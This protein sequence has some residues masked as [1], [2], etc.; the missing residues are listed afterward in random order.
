MVLLVVTVL[1]HGISSGITRINAVQLHG[2]SSGITRSNGVIIWHF[3]W[4]YS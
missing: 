3:Q 2:I 4:Y 1:L